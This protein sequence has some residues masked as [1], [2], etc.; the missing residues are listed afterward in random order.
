MKSSNGTRLSVFLSIL[1]ISLLSVV[2]G[3]AGL[4]AN[5]DAD[6]GV[7]LSVSLASATVS[8]VSTAE[9]IPVVVTGTVAAGA[10]FDTFTVS[11]EVTNGGGTAVTKRGV[12][13][14][15]TAT[16]TLGTAM[17][18][19]ATGTGIGAFSSTLTGLSPETTYY[20]R[21]YATSTIGTGYGADITFKTAADLLAGFALVSAGPFKMGDALDGLIDA[22]VRMV[23]VS[24][25]YMGKTEVTL[26]QWQ[27]VY[28]WAKDNGYS[29]LYS[30]SGK[31]PDHPV[32][33][34]N[35]Y[36]VVKWC[37]AKSQQ[38]GLTPVYYTDDAHTMIYK[39][40]NVD[41]T[42][43]QVKWTA[44]GYRLPTEAEW[45]KAARGGLIGQRFSRGNMINQNVAN[46]HGRTA[47][48]YDLGP[49]GF[50]QRYEV[51]GPP[52]TSP[53]GSFAANGYGLHDMEGNVWEWCWDW[54]GAYESGAPS[55]PKGATLGSVRGLRGSGWNDDASYCRA[56]FRY[57]GRTTLE[58]GNVGFRLLRGY[59]PPVEPFV[60][61]V[62]TGAAAATETAFDTFTVSGNVTH[63][64]GAPVT[65][66]GVVYGPTATPT[67]GTAIDAPAIGTGT[68]LFSSILT[69]LAAETTYYARTYAISTVGTGYGTDITFKTAASTTPGGF[70]L[71]PAGPFQMGDALDGSSDAP[72]RTINVSA[73]YMAKTEVTKGEWDQVRAWGLSRGYTD[74]AVGVGKASNHPVEQVG[75]WDV[76]KWCNARSEKDGLEPVYSVNGI[77]MRTENTE[78]TANWAAK[79]YRLPTE[80]EWEKAARGGLSSKRFPWGDTISHSQANYYSDSFFSYDISPT[81]GLH[82]IYKEGNR[83]YN[84]P[85]ESFV[86]NGYGLHDMTGNVFEWCWDRYDAT[87]YRSSPETD[88]RGP[89]SG[90]VRV[91][92]GGSWDGSATFGRVAFRYWTSPL[93][94]FN[95]FGFRPVRGL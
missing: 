14:G 34:V 90:S 25:F 24:A 21:A 92:R 81:R 59:T 29:D 15:L 52:Y 62:I 80:A 18:A 39:T 20:A 9:S 49:N 55:D 48:P 78:P 69:G 94:W 2:R 13:Y 43:S 7:Q 53:V 65:R 46:Y 70:A 41:V 28:F 47:V 30:G 79:G 27:A 32:H 66:R 31:A 56:A 26:S 6:L 68:G 33:T 76:I 61:T 83:P 91:V 85:V 87:Y 1:I 35:W 5:N 73:F 22:P 40:G 50:H 36:E 82:P 75:W 11:G 63:D 10:T 16:P 71:I 51:G 74:L 77:I 37:N 8:T 54:F 67:L 95:D 44:N 88:P 64:G 17:D 38:A 86:A 4:M 60:P 84:S 12:V 23:N 42:S 89:S 57:Y 93:R 19:P 72:V 3:G 45:E 58:Y